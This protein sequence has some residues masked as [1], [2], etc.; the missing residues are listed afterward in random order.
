MEA[1][2]RRVHR[3]LAD[4]LAGVLEGVDDPGVAAA[5]DDHQPSRGVEDQGHVL[6]DGI[7]DEAAGRLD[8]AL[9]APVPL[10]MR[11][12]HRPGQPGAGEDLGRPRDLDERAAGRLERRLQGD[13]LVRLA[14]AF[15]RAAQ[16]DAGSDVA[17]PSA[18]GF[19]GQARGGA[20]AGR[21]CGRRDD[22]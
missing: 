4:R 20:P 12:G 5:R 2:E 13:R 18:L 15:A 10:G 16:E 19:S 6:G 21:R 17:R 11:A 14:T 22:G 3:S 1:A 8:L 7:L 9:A